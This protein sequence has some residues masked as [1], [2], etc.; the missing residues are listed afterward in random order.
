MQVNTTLKPGL[1]VSLKTTITGN[2]SYFRKT[3]EGEHVTANGELR[4]SWETEKKVLNA[5]EHDLAKKAR[6]DARN[7]ISAAC[8]ISAFGLLCPVDNEAKLKEAIGK[9]QDIVNSFN[10]TATLSE[11]ALYV[12]VGRIADDDADAEKAINSEVLDLLME[13]DAGLEAKDVKATRDACN[14]ARY[15][16]AMLTEA[17]A[18]A[19]QGAIDAS[20][21]AASKI[22][23]NGDAAEVG[24]MA[25]NTLETTMAYFAK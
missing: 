2:V 10:Q 1:L 3:I 22:V 25:R 6:A 17:P 19:L 12:I 24:V 16:L 11:I 4:A 13:M 21:E 9:A 23:K 20:R 8:S 18:R 15:L 14:K 5:A 7:A